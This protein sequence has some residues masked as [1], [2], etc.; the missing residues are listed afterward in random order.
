MAL[1][2]V[3]DAQGALFFRDGE[4]PRAVALIAGALRPD[5]LA[6]VLAG[7]G[8]GPL[9]ASEPTRARLD[10]ARIEELRHGVTMGAERSAAPSSAPKP[11]Q[12]PPRSALA[13]SPPSPSPP[14][15]PAAAA[16]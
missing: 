4:G 3:A 11:P 1:G 6:A 12:S 9:V 2:L 14:P 5:A 8:S 10:L 7:L 13:P 15:P 16:K